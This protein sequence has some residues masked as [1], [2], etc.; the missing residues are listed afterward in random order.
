MPWLDH[1]FAKNPV[2]PIG[3]A[4]FGAIV[5]F[6]VQRLVERMQSQGTRTEQSQ[7]DY[8]DYFMEKMG[9]E[10]WITDQQ[11]VGWLMINVNTIPPPL[12]PTII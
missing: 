3:Q 1:L 6:S 9:S 10:P 11:V 7:K 2:H 5:Q 4:S 12:N 8:L